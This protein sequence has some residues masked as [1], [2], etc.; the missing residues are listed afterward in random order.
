ML[1]A[2]HPRDTATIGGREAATALKVLHVLPHPGGGGET[3]VDLLERMERYRFERR[4]L[5]PSPRPREAQALIQRA[6]RANLAARRADV[7]HVHGE[8]ASTLTLPAL[9][10]RPSVVTLHGT[11]LFRRL[12]G[13]ARRAAATNLR[14]IISA[15]TRTICVSPVERDLV[16]DALGTRVAE[17]LV[18]I[19]NGVTPGAAVTTVERATART[20]LG[21]EKEDVV[22]LWLGGLDVHK[23][24]LTAVRAATRAADADPRLKLLVVGNGPLRPEAVRVASAG[25]PGAV[26]VLGERRDVRFVLAASDFLVVSSRREGLSFAL[27]EA[28]ALGLAPLVTDAPEN[29]AAAGDAGIV[30]PAGDEQALV[31]L[32]LWLA[33]SESERARLGELARLRVQNHFRAEVMQRLTAA[34]YDEV[35]ERRH[36]P[37]S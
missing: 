19:R 35:R 16:V 26:Q 12:K 30:F 9:V 14:L 2:R 8:V 5:A 15:A 1:G 20:A 6:V 17:R 4:Y 29:V 27:L 36:R 11:H 24:P 18:V 10:R 33:R 23:D 32:L 21:L 25:E 31:D 22:G 3:Y 28:M 37:E 13:T 34:V 7:L